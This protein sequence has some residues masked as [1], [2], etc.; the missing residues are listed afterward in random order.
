MAGQPG[1]PAH[2]RVSVNRF[3]EQLFGTG[4]VESLEDFGTQGLSPSHPVLLNYLRRPLH[5][6]P[7]MEREGPAS[8]NRHF[9][10]LPAGFSVH[11]RAA[12]KRSSKP[13]SLHAAPASGCP[14]E[15]IRDQALFVSGILS[16]KM[17]GPSVKPPQP[18]G[19]WQNPYDGTSW[20]NK[21]RRR[22]LPARHLHLL[23]EDGAL[24]VHGYVRQ[25]EPRILRVPAHPDQHAAAGTC[26]AQ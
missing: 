17:Y 15:Q 10:H 19:L 16:D 24:S 20:V 9:S 13:A 14:P 3:W 21:Q 5:G 18:E 7:C 23:A 4:I 22:S 1:Q 6:C 11:T 26:D 25:P 2:G 8:G 12:G